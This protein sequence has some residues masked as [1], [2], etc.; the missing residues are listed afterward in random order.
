MKLGHVVP[1]DI[2]HNPAARFGRS[3]LIVEHCQTNHEIAR[4]SMGKPARARCVACQHTAQ[5]GLVWPGNI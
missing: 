3:A 2:L 1:G 4:G 5:S